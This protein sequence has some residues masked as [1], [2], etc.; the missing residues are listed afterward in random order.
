MNKCLQDDLKEGAE[1]PLSKEDISQYTALYQVAE[2]QKPQSI[3]NFD[4]VCMDPSYTNKMHHCLDLKH[5][6]QYLDEQ[7]NTQDM[8]C[9][10]AHMSLDEEVMRQMQEIYK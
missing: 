3:C 7:T 2:S 9:D 10:W 4:L 1:K 5:K 8:F 6:D